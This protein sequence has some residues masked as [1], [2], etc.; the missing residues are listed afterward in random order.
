MQGT[1]SG[2]VPLTGGTT[3]TEIPSRLLGNYDPTQP[4]GNF[5]TPGNPASGIAIKNH[6]AQGSS[7]TFAPPYLQIASP[8]AFTYPATASDAVLGGVPDVQSSPTAINDTEYPAIDSMYYY[9][10]QNAT[11]VTNGGTGNTNPSLPDANGLRRSCR[12]ALAPVDNVHKIRQV[13]YFGRV[14]NVPV[15]QV[16]TTPDVRTAG[17][18]PTTLPVGSQVQV[19][20]LYCMDGFTGQV[21]WRYQVPSFNLSS[22]GTL[23]TFNANITGTVHSATLA[24]VQ[25]FQVGP[26]AYTT[27]GG[28][29]VSEGSPT[30]AQHRQHSYGTFTSYSATGNLPVIG[31]AMDLNKY[32]FTIYATSAV[33]NARRHG[34]LLRH[35]PH[36]RPRLRLHRRRRADPGT[37]DLHRHRDLHQR[38]RR[39]RH[40]HLHRRQG[41]PPAARLARPRGLL[42]RQPGPVHRH[43]QYHRPAAS[44]PSPATW[45]HPRRRRRPQRLGLLLALPRQGERLQPGGRHDRP[46][47]VRLLRRQ[48]RLRLL[49]GRP[50]Q[51]RRHQ[52]QQCRPEHR[53]PGRARVR[54]PAPGRLRPADLGGAGPDA[55]P[56]P[57]VQAR[58]DVGT[59]NAFWVYRPDPSRPKQT[60]SFTADVSAQ[61]QSASRSGPQPIQVGPSAATEG[62]TSAALNSG[63]AGSF[64]SYVGT[65]SLPTITGG[66]LSKYGFTLYTTNVATVAGNPLPIAAGV[67]P[68]GPTT[69]VYTG[70]FRIYAP[71][72][73]TAPMTDRSSNTASSPSRR[74]SRTPTTP[75]WWGRSTADPGAFKPPSWPVPV[76]FSPANP[77]PLPVTTATFPST[78][79][80]FVGSFHSDPNP[81]VPQTITGRLASQPGVKTADQADSKSDLPVPQAFGLA[82]PTVYV[83]PATQAGIVYVGSSN[84][85]LYALDATGAPIDGASQTTL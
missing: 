9:G 79:P 3:A 39:Q 66:D 52:Q 20:A 15:I 12:A 37:R 77:A 25:P 62:S 47:P 2:L 83:D 29:T 6:F 74:L 10:V 13:V 72:T 24:G 28:T 56:T 63:P 38:D 33:V 17:G 45:R 76:D 48:Q 75:R 23:N 34:D 57:A 54:Q 53:H 68:T 21:I 41:H 80:N 84:G 43:V 18:V 8:L 32:G 4:P 50:G 36:L 81:A 58:P 27:K 31:A 51:P 14:E 60:N 16:T 71:G 73:A 70:T 11:S 61:V 5:V 67:S 59:T 26:T 35:V 19:G 42:P 78:P 1:P 82:S 30:R 7:G 46:A 40:R 49:P 69:V 22:T 44:R 65:G 85:V 64:T 55:I